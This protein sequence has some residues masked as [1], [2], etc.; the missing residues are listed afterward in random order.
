MTS[1]AVAEARKYVQESIRSQKQLGYRR[2][3]RPDVVK[4]AVSEAAAALDAL[5]ALH[6]K[7]A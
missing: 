7:K 5:V 6:A 1:Q 4:A 2:S 3:P